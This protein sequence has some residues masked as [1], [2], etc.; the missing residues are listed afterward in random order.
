MSVCEPVLSCSHCSFIIPLAK[1][2]AFPV[3]FCHQEDILVKKTDQVAQL[4]AR[5]DRLT[6]GLTFC[7]IHRF[8]KDRLSSIATMLGTLTA[9]HLQVG[10]AVRC[11]THSNILHAILNSSLQSLRILQQI[12]T[13]SH[14]IHTTLSVTTTDGTVDGEQVDGGGGAGGRGSGSLQRH[15]QQP[16]ELRRPGRGARLQRRRLRLS[17]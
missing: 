12:T 16:R 15:R 10:T 5:V 1:A 9:T 17:N 2:V 4:Q 7:E 11:C 3:H 8:N 13:Q 14:F 6:K